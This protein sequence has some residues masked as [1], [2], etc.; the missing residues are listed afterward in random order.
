MT[1]GSESAR[2]GGKQRAPAVTA[3]TTCKLCALAGAGKGANQ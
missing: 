2:P 1:R 3:A